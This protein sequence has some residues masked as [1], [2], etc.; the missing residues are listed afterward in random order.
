MDLNCPE[1]AVKKKKKNNNN[2]YCDRSI[3]FANILVFLNFM[4]ISAILLILKEQSIKKNPPP[5]HDKVLRTDMYGSFLLT[6]LALRSMD[7]I[8]L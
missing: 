7:Y 6:N 5:F 1:I 8:I 3:T 2:F 4:H